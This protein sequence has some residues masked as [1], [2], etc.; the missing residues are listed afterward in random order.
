[1][2]FKKWG[3]I[4][5]LNQNEEF[6]GEIEVLIIFS[7]TFGWFMFRMGVLGEI[8]DHVVK[9][10]IFQSKAFSGEVIN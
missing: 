2:F 5:Y 6:L 3:N 7:A 4:I 9:F 8:Q 10:C 1:M